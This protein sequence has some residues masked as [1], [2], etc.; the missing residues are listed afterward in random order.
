MEDKLNLFL[1]YYLW[2]DYREKYR[3]ALT[4][5]SLTADL[6]RA[7]KFWKDVHND[8]A[9]PYAA[10]VF[11]KII[12]DYFVVNGDGE[13]D[14]ANEFEKIYIEMLDNEQR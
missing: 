12:H 2:E 13:I 6:L 10:K 8:E 14:L 1:E 5:Q 7:F 9:G 11:G 4:A 3:D